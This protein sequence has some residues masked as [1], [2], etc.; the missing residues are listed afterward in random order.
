MNTIEPG[1]NGGFDVSQY[2]PSGLKIILNVLGLSDKVLPAENVQIGEA[3]T[4]ALD[5]ASIRDDVKFKVMAQPGGIYH[6]EVWTNRLTRF[7][8]HQ[9]DKIKGTISHPDYVSHELSWEGERG[10]LTNTQ[11]VECTVYLQRGR[12][13]GG[14]V[15]D[16]T[17]RPLENVRVFIQYYV[18]PFE[19]GLTKTLKLR[20]REFISQRAGFGNPPAAITDRMGRWTIQN[21]SQSGTFGRIEMQR[22][23]GAYFYRDVLITSYP[24]EPIELRIDEGYSIRGAV[25]DQNSL[26]VTGVLV[27]EGVLVPRSGELSGTSEKLEKMSELK[28][29]GNGLFQA[30]HRPSGPIVFLLTKAGYAATALVVTNRPY[31]PECRVMMAPARPIHIQV[32]DQQGNPIPNATA[33]FQNFD[34][35]YRLLDWRGHSDAQGIIVWSEPPLATVSISVYAASYGSRSLTLQPGSGEQKIVLPAISEDRITVKGWI[36]DGATDLPVQDF[37]VRIQTDPDKWR[38]ATRG[39]NGSFRFSLLKMEHFPEFSPGF[40]RLRFESDGYQPIELNKMDYYRGDQELDLLMRKS[41]GR[42]GTVLLTNGKPADWATVLVPNQ[43]RS[44][45]LT[46]AKKPRYSVADMEADTFTQWNGRLDLPPIAEIKPPFMHHEPGMGVFSARWNR[47][48]DLPPPADTRSL[49]I[50][51]ESGVGV[52][53]ADQL[54]ADRPLI[55]SPYGH[56]KGQLIGG[57]HLRRNKPA[58]GRRVFLHT[59]FDVP[60][61]V[62]LLSLQTDTDEKGEFRFENIPP[63]QYQIS[64]GLPSPGGGVIPNSIRLLYPAARIRAGENTQQFRGGGWVRIFGK[65]AS[66]DPAEVDLKNDYTAILKLADIP[67][68]HRALYAS[69]AEYET[70]H[71]TW[72]QAMNEPWRKWRQYPVSFKK[73]GASFWIEDVVPGDYILTIAPKESSLASANGKE[74]AGRNIGSLR[75]EIVVPLCDT[76]PQ[77]VLELGVMETKVRP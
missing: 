4:A 8:L 53:C 75:Q 49:F 67:K 40:Y 56:L 12:Q 61:P 42:R 47:R 60:D 24:G 77:G 58:A 28:T 5:H 66:A 32:V 71:A 51:H 68:P 37:M 55:L 34:T 39:S 27:Q 7:P 50:Q 23:D 31:L 29:D 2:Q 63:G 52:F 70:A 33:S 41:D 64:Q 6:L 54:T 44:I 13:I 72:Q 46:G 25:V 1:Q 18:G 3:L 14:L 69:E 35:P 43:P 45:H 57:S 19:Q 20:E 59:S 73:D 65:I 74:R 10:L 16:A 62:F 26:P 30:D 9:V 15:T 21:V 11:P 22:P 48:L 17:G 76:L 38:I 36:R